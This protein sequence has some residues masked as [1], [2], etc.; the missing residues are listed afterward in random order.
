[1]Y[2]RIFGKI[3]KKIKK[4]SGNLEKDRN[5]YEKGHREKR[6]EI[7]ESGNGIRKSMGEELPKVVLNQRDKHREKKP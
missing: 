6:N 5:N 3:W 4:G 2:E 1:L 7:A